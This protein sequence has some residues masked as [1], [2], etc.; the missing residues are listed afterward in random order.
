MCQKKKKAHF[1]DDLVLTR[2]L[3]VGCKRK[4]KDETKRGIPDLLLQ[5]NTTRNETEGRVGSGLS[6]IKL[7]K[8]LGKIPQ[9]QSRRTNKDKVSY[10]GNVGKIGKKKR[11]GKGMD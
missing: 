3:K 9:I 2:G 7:K 6:E 1:T 8:W 4:S 10:P 11:Q 5:I